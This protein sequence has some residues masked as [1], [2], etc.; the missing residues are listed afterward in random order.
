MVLERPARQ[1][2]GNLWRLEKTAR[3][4]GNLDWIHYI[5]AVASLCAF[6]FEHWGHADDG[7]ETV[8]CLCW[9]KGMEAGVQGTTEL[10]AGTG[11]R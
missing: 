8:D 2:L 11:V 9:R 1:T 10:Y 7:C 4:N 6:L 5:Q 3:Q